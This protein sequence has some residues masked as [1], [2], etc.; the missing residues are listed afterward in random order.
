MLRTEFDRQGMIEFIF[1]NTLPI[2]PLFHSHSFHEV[3]Y[4]H[5]GKCSYLIG[6]KIYML[7]PGDLILM[8]GMTLHCAKV[9]LSY[10]YV[11]SIIHFEPAGAA[12]FLEMPNSVNILQPFQ[13]LK[14][15][16]ISLRGEEQAEVERLLSLMEHHC[17]KANQIGNFREIN[18]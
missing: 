14:N 7:A 12:P 17:Q 9:D 11:R 5:S 8:H 10:E 1:R 16:R 15:H 6:D 4:F 2:D 3:Y 18:K 13:E